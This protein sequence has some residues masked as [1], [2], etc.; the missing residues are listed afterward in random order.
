MTQSN[1]QETRETILIVDDV[2]ENL[3]VL[4]RILAPDYD[5]RVAQ[6]G[7]ETLKIAQEHPELDLILLDVMMPEMGGFETCSLLKSD[8]LTR[9]IPVIF[10]TSRNTAIDEARGFDVGGVDYLTKPINPSIVRSRVRTHLELSS[11]N[12]RLRMQ[13]KALQENV[14]LLEQIQQ[15]ARHDLKAPLSIFMGAS[16][17][18]EQDGNLTPRQLQFL[19]VLDRSAMKMLNMIDRTLDL[20]KMER[21]L[22][23]LHP[24]LVDILNLAHL[25]LLELESL[26]RKKAV[27]C[28]MSLDGRVPDQADT[29]LVQGETYLLATIVSNLAK[30]AIEA[31]P[32]GGTVC[33]ALETGNPF[34]IIISNQGTIPPEILPRFLERYVTF[35]KPNGTGLGGYSARLMARTLGG[36]IKYH[37]A[38]ESGTVLTVSLPNP[39]MPPSLQSSSD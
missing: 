24:N 39:A 27:G 16:D 17:L 13:N 29:A 38:P 8:S 32:E 14:H 20:Y 12:R 19:R 6:N 9:E 11:A 37:S 7:H 31:S 25:A 2:S 35:G 34:R 36:D 18:L 5:V 10:V 33:L 15:I 21:G 28:V 4:G 3:E 1:W 22:Y 23:Q 30:N 26:S